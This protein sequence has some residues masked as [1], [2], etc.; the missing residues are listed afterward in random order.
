M[1][2]LRTGS[3]GALLLAAHAHVSALVPAQTTSEPVQQVVVNGSAPEAR[4]QSSATAIVVRREELLRQWRRIRE[5][6]PHVVIPGHNPP[7]VLG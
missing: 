3:A 1:H 7:V 6:K 5:L 4:A 2:F